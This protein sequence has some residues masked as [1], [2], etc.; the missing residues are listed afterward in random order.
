MIMGYSNFCCDNEVSHKQE[1]RNRMTNLLQEN[2]E[3]KSQLPKHH[4]DFSPTL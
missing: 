2:D 1:E 3:I 4:I